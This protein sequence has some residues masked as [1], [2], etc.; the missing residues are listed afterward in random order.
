DSLVLFDEIG[1]PLGAALM[2]RSLAT[3]AVM[4]GDYDRAER[5]ALESLRR[6]EHLGA[7]RGAGESCLVLADCALAHEQFDDAVAWCERARDAFLKRGFDGDVVLAL[8]I[9]AR[10]ALARGDVS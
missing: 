5:L 2:I 9:S 7:V 10:I 3:I 4:E 6:N 8:E 1:E